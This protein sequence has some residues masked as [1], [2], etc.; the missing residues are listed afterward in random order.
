MNVIVSRKLRVALV[1]VAAVASLPQTTCG[2]ES[3]NPSPAHRV[4]A[5]IKHAN[6]YAPATVQKN[7]ETKE[8]EPGVVTMERFT[9]VES[10]RARQFEQKIERDNEKRRAEKFSIIKGGTIWKKGRIEI[11]GWGAPG[12]INFL[13]YSW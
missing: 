9:V 13:K 5:L 10:M 3:V 11:G 8:P 4:S 6:P 2:Q 1:V 7:E 12:G